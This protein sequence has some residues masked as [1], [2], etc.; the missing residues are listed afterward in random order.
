MIRSNNI[1]V[2]F[3]SVQDVDL[4][5]IEGKPVKVCFLFGKNPPKVSVELMRQAHR[6]HDQVQMINIES[7][8]KNALDFVLAHQTG[9]QTAV[10][11]ECGIHILSK[12]KGFDALITHL[13]SRNVQAAR[14]EVFSKIPVLTQERK[15]VP[16]PAPKPKPKPKTE[17]EDRLERVKA[18]FSKMK[19]SANDGRPKKRKTLCTKI[20]EVFLKAL[21][22]DEVEKVIRGLEQK[23][24]IEISEDKVT[25]H[26]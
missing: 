24:W 8:G 1:F 13:K 14:D 25:Y 4:K 22:A 9:I 3:E 19:H 26:F 2:D 23:G 6:L 7:R 5:L 17:P 10:D 12:D 16:K 21:S 11:P 20:Q 18:R 15:S